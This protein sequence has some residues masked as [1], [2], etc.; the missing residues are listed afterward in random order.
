MAA[1]EEAETEI[2]YDPEHRDVHA[3]FEVGEEIGRGTFSI[4]YYGEHRI[5][6][7]PVAVK[8][9]KKTQIKPHLLAREVSIMRKLN[10]P[11]VLP[12]IDVFETSNEIYLM[13]ELVSG[14]ELFDRIVDK[15]NY[16]EGDAAKIVEQLLDAVIYLHEHG[17]V[18]RDLKPENLLCSDGDD[19]QLTIKVAD[20]GLSRM[21]AE[22]GLNTYCGSPEYVAPEVLECQPYGGAVDLWSVG[23][24][25]YILLTGFLPFYDKTHAVLFQKIK[26]V[27]YN[28]DEC[29]E[30]SEDAKDFIEHLLVKYPQDRFTAEQALGHPWIANISKRERVRVS[31]SFHENI[32]DFNEKRR[33]PTG[34]PAGSFILDGPV[35]EM[36]PPEPKGHRPKSG[37]SGKSEKKSKKEGGSLRS[38]RRSKKEKKSG[39]GSGSLRKGE[40][41]TRKDSKG[42]DP[43]SNS[44]K[45]SSSPT[46]SKSRPRS[47]DKRA[48]KESARRK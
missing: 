14:G 13:L 24:I 23:V 30:I 31:S 17:I 2:S 26:K 20:F 36:Q 44:R 42:E 18:H 10:H 12:L 32:R 8:V 45:G 40:T 22:G 3:V 33:T 19:S 46:S 4:V 34:S 43:G 48:K 38:S 28:W 11:N 47:T 5:T 37:K 6:H 35:P 7:Q 16:S 27:D 15:G 41:R 21:F 39:S 29:P 9:I 25:T 1:E